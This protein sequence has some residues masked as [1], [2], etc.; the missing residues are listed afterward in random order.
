MMIL[1]IL[2]KNLE[3]ARFIGL[4]L[5]KDKMKK[6]FIMFI[7]MQMKKV[8]YFGGIQYFKIITGIMTTLYQDTDFQKFYIISGAHINNMYPYK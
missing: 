6:Q 8:G 4:R 3:E 7:I 5:Q 1:F 2:F